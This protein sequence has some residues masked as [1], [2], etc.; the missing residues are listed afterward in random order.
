MRK[1]KTIKIDEKEITVL[2][3]KVSDILEILGLQE[4]KKADGK[5]SEGPGDQLKDLVAIIRKY[6]PQFVQNITLE[7]M[8]DMAPSEIEQVYN[9]FKEV[10]STF[11]SLAQRLK[12]GEMLERMK[13]AIIADCSA[14][15]AGFL[16]Q[17][18][19]TPGNTDSPSS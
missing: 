13:D 9:A 12:L 5:I 15:F 19:E 3:V 17:G 18:T 4:E 8:I 14:M 11:F 1:R 10:N 2:E 7:D 6:L 16:K